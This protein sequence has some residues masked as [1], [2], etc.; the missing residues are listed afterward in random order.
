[1]NNSFGNIYRLTTFGE[2]HGPAI[3]GIIDGI[4]SN[5]DINI[6]K[7]QLALN[8]RKPGQSSLSTPRKENDI[9]EILS[10]IYK[11]KTLGSP[12]G[13]II[14][15]HDIKSN[16][17]DE[18]IYRPSHGDFTYEAK[19]K[20]RDY[21]GGGRASARETACRIVAG[22][23]AKQILNQIA[24]INVYTCI[25]QIG[26]IKINEN[27]DNEIF[28]KEIEDEILKVKKTGDSIGG[29][30]S[31]IIDCPVG[32]GEP[33]YNKLQSELSSAMFSIPGVK[34]FEY[35]LGFD[36]CNKKG[37]EVND[38]FYSDGINIFTKS[39]NSG[40]IQGGISNGQPIYF[41]VAFKPTPSISIEQS[42][43]D[44]DLNN[45]HTKIKGRHDPCIVPRALYVVEAMTYIVMLDQ[46]MMNRSK[47]FY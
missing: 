9:V 31:C 1:M 23:I 19:Y 13:F 6:E 26:N 39:N 36:F 14:R 2:S 10:G 45:I 30:I 7:I 43:I 33:V 42:T 22:E 25:S 35:G 4:P 21:R 34:G 8:K 3:G 5:L 11:N 29:K 28:K 32:L 47:S 41:N 20:I 15:N 12:I 18:N 44:K 37:S 46:I 16:D 27:S 38:E 40:G 24:K 17:Y